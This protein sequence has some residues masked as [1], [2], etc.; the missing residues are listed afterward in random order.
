MIP[1]SKHNKDA[2]WEKRRQQDKSKTWEASKLREVA[3]CKLCGATRCV[4]SKCAV[5]S[6]NGPTTEELTRLQQSIESNG[7]VCG[8]R[9]KGCG[10]K[11]YSKRAMRCG[12]YI[13]SQYYNPTMGTKGGRIVVSDNLCAI[14]YVEDDIVTP[15]ED[16]ES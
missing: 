14:C 16:D 6:K 2:D 4:F 3:I 10:S 12:N 1:T 9:I 13:E 15:N 8:D 7:Y 5:G 11:F